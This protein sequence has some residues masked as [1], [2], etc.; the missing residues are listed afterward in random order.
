MF[1][2]YF[3]HFGS[4]LWGLWGGRELASAWRKLASA[5]DV[6]FTSVLGM[7]G[8]G[9]VNVPFVI[10]LVLFAIVHLLYIVLFCFLCGAIV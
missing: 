1:Y 8:G 5:L 7:Q 9:G 6:N 10:F 3:D 4:S 2:L